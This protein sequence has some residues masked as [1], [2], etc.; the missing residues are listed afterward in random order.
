MREREGECTDLDDREV[1]RVKEEKT[2]IRI[3]CVKIIYF[4]KSPKDQTR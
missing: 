4:L 3:Y 2:T 1:G